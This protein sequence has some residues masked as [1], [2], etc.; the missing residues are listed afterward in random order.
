M[1]FSKNKNITR[2]EISNAQRQITNMQMFL[3]HSNISQNIQIINVN[4]EK[5]SWTKF[6]KLKIDYYS[7]QKI[8]HKVYSTWQM[9]ESRIQELIKQGI[10]EI[11]KFSYLVEGFY[12]S[13]CG[14]LGSLK[15]QHFCSFR[16][17]YAT[18][19]HICL[20]AI[21]NLSKFYTSLANIP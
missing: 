9:E 16:E 10:F 2:K 5:L 8:M 20:N 1:E 3:Q 14:Y 19:K 13:K 12:C 7:E 15:E 4:R 6:L 18:G 21:K 11:D 17:K